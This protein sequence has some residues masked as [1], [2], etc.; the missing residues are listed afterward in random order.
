MFITVLVAG[1]MFSVLFAS[2]LII[3]GVLNSFERF[4]QTSNQS[5]LVKT[6]SSD[7]F[8]YR[9]LPPLHKDDVQARAEANQH[10][11]QYIEEQKALAKQHKIDFDEKSV[12]H[13]IKK[14]KLGDHEEY[15]YDGESPVL[16]RI[17]LAEQQ[18]FIAEADS[19]F[20]GLKKR[21]Q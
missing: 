21:A 8:M 11:L 10:Y 3:S 20:Q 12:K 14:Y 5:Y 17:L 2:A 13:P 1:L 4:D 18:K 9:H 6:V 15:I 7:V 19:N 16:E